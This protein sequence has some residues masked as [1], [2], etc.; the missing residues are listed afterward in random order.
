VPTVAASLGREDPNA[1]IYFTLQEQD[2]GLTCQAIGKPEWADGAAHATAQAHQPHIFE[3]FAEIEKWLADRTK[4]EAVDVLRTYEVPC[5]PVF[6]MNELAYDPDLCRSGTVVEVEQ[7]QRGTYLTVGSPI[8]F[9]SFEPVITPTGS[10]E[11]R[12]RVVALRFG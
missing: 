8:K 11:G 6:S 1:Y 4:Y 3:I 5:A 7:K 10:R 2:W 12:V 9:T